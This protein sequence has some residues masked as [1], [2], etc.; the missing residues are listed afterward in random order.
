MPGRNRRHPEG[1]GGEP[2]GD[3]ADLARVRHELLNR[4][5]VVSGF[6]ALVA[7][8]VGDVHID[9]VREH[10]NRLTE[11]SLQ[12]DA[13]LADWSSHLGGHADP[14]DGSAVVQQ[15][16][17]WLAELPGDSAPQ[18]LIVEDDD[19]H[20]HLLQ[21][22][23][24]QASGAG[25]QIVRCTTLREACRQLS[26]ARPA[27]ALLDL[28][29]PDA[30]GLEALVA[31]HTI[32][33]ELPVIVTTG[34]SDVASGIDAVRHGA[35]D[36]LV[37]GG[38][39]RELLERTVVYAVERARLEAQRAHEALHDSLT[40]LANRKLFQ[41][42]LALA[43]ARLGRSSARIAVLF[44]D[45]DQFKFINDTLGHRVG[46]ELL[47]GVARRFQTAVRRADT[48]ARVGGDEFVLLFE[49]LADDGEAARLAENALDLF[50]APFEYA[51]GLQPMT[52]SI[53][54]AMSEG[55]DTS[56][57][58]LLANA[59]TAMYRAKEDGRSRWELF[60]QEMRLRLVDR[61]ETERHLTQAVDRGELE[62]RYQPIVELRSGRV[63][64][65]EALLRW[66]H[67]ERGLLS[68]ADFLAVAEDSGK[69]V[70][71]GAW[72]VAEACDQAR[73]WQAARP[74][75]PGFVIWVNASSRQFE[76]S[77]LVDGV[78]AALGATHEG[79]DLGLEIT[80]SVLIRDLDRASALLT[81]LHRRGVRLAVD[82]FGTGFSSLRWL[83]A[84]PIDHLK[85][86]RSFVSG[87]DIEPADTAI[88][89]ACLGL[90]RGLGM[91][92]V[93]EGIETPRQL[94]ALRALGCATGQGYLFAQPLT[95]E[96]IEPLLRTDCFA[97]AGLPRQARAASNQLVGR[98]E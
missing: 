97:L 33:P 9:V 17:A 89:S 59:D 42:R 58:E 30:V 80:E 16:T 79:W 64:G 66:R 29:L 65:A 54:V 22:L 52:A 43:C 69:I 81:P 73:R 68:P 92:C 93:A 24:G 94:A 78:I 25:W 27:C 72:A 4:A 5:A 87:V 61:F 23:L 67:P 55:P 35:Q 51:G 20:F 96:Q 7:D 76:S 98:H 53:G 39:T 90:G 95:P 88:V 19:D 46:D 18:L 21:S 86:D 62:L 12:M 28:S 11:N 57:E 10:L 41:D 91:D 38:I 26:S 31:L 45:L 14:R 60:D 74:L 36:Y 44:V 75:P 40:G 63:L 77:E 82:D 50:T 3:H 49:D 48:V 70:D 85:I 8:E 83:R 47:V 2:V 84:L 32:E 6:A 15:R 56:P 34:Y 71:L 37:K 13:L 1:R